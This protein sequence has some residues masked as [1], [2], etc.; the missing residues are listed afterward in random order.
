MHT[1]HHPATKSPLLGMNTKS[2]LLAFKFALA[3]KISL[4]QIPSHAS[5]PPLRAGGPER[6]ASGAGRF[7]CEA[8]LRVLERTWQG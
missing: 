7:L 4:D 5:Q 2:C 8:R 3:L 6:D 1:E